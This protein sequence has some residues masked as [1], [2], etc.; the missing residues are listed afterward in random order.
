LGPRRLILGIGLHWNCTVSVD[1]LEKD[2][3][4]RHSRGSGN[5]LFAVLCDASAV[6]GR[7]NYGQAKMVSPALMAVS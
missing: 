4:N 7:A 3:D 1:G 6:N 5:R 2:N